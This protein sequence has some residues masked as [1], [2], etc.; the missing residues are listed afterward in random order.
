MRVLISVICLSTSLKNSVFLS[1]AYVSNDLFR[2]KN[3]LMT[4]LFLE[5]KIRLTPFSFKLLK[6]ECSKSAS[7]KLKPGPGHRERSHLILFHYR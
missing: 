5:V 3:Y 1:G 4:F 6:K 2:E 7:S